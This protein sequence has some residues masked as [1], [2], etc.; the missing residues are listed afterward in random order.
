[1]RRHANRFFTATVRYSPIIKEIKPW[2]KKSHD[3]K[4]SRRPANGMFIPLWDND[5]HRKAPQNRQ[6]AGDENRTTNAFVWAS[7]N[8]ERRLLKIAVQILSDIYFENRDIKKDIKPPHPWF[9]KAPHPT[10]N[11]LWSFSFWNMTLSLVV[12]IKKCRTVLE[13]A[14]RNMDQDFPTVYL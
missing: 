8:L 9:S 5:S 14:L 1:M 7:R 2:P 11:T 12:G 6:K 13:Q 3:M 10:T 4:S